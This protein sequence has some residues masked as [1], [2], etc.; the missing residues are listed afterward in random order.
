MY[1]ASTPRQ[2]QAYTVLRDKP[3]SCANSEGDTRALGIRIEIRVSMR[4]YPSFR[5]YKL[6]RH[7]YRFSCSV[8]QTQI[9]IPIRDCQQQN[10]YEVLYDFRKRCERGD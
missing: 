1:L 3:S 9:T 5:L 4:Q 7:P 8:Q 10:T 2:H 6:I